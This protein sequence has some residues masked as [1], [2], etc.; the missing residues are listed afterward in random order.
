MLCYRSEKRSKNY[1]TFF[2]CQYDDIAD[3]NECDVNNGG[4]SHECVNTRGSYECICPKGFKVQMDQ[5]TCK[6]TALLILS[7]QRLL[8]R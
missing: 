7:S 1:V 5:E 3:I 2:V 8:Q 4:C 6:G